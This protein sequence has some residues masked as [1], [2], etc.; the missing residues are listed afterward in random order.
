[1]ELEMPIYRP[2][3]LQNWLAAFFMAGCL[4]AAHWIIPHKT[5]YD[6]LGRPDYQQIIPA[7]FGDWT[8]SS[9]G[10]G[11]LFVDP[12]QQ[13][14]LH[15]L[16]TQIVSRTYV[17]KSTGRRIMLSLA[18]GDIQTY[19]KQLHRPE[20]C[21]SSQGHKIKNLHQDKLQNGN[22]QIN[23]YRMTATENDQREQVSYWIRIGDTVISGPP[24]SLNIQRM[25]MDLKGY[26]TD[27]LLFRVSEIENDAQSSYTLQNQFIQD[28]LNALSPVQ[29]ALL[30]GDIVAK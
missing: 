26:I 5:W 15:N 23:L 12:Q 10:A 17:Q 25:K 20:S 29:Q 18:Y 27:G 2:A 7:Q 16:Y 1:M 8:E 6:H 24:G 30:I 14:A 9:D 22:R 28:F 21:Y 3:R 19:D 4:L 13:D 11:H